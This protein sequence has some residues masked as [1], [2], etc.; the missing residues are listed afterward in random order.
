[1]KALKDQYKIKF[2]KCGFHNLWNS[3]GNLGGYSRAKDTADCIK[4]VDGQGKYND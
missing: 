1:L 4:D 3:L 2:Q